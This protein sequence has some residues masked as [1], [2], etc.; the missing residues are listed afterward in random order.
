MRILHLTY[1]VSPHG[2]G[3]GLIALNLAKAQSA[4]GLDPVIWCLDSEAVCLRV[5]ETANLSPSRIRSFPMVG[6]SQFAFSPALHSAGKNEGSEFAVIH[7]HGIWTA[8]S[9]VTKSIVTR[10]CRP[11]VVA[12]HGSLHEFVLRKSL[13]KKRLASWAYESSNLQRAACLHATAPGELEDFRQYGLRNPIALITNGISDEW[14]AAEGDG[15]RFLSAY[16]IPPEARILLFMSR[17][18]PKKGLLML[19]Q[20]W[21]RATDSDSNWILVV[22]GGDEGGHKAE[23]ENL[24][25]QLN[26]S[27]RVRFVGPIFEQGKR[28]AFTASELFVLPSLS[29]GFPMVVLDALG[30]G[31]PAIVTHA[32]AW[33]DLTR[34]HC[35]WWVP[36]TT[37]GLEQGIRSAISLSPGELRDMGANGRA[38]VASRYNESTLARQTLELYGWL[39]GQSAQPQFVSTV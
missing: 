38:L 19:L 15:A 36:T 31:V 30:A 6:P 10:H 23:A 12:P 17:I 13:W 7:Q 22:V 28:D 39:R 24:C 20:A 32:S 2:Y 25:E 35:G 3:L 14:L 27:Q 16:A 18:T 34:H 1:S 11:S 33:E 21:A 5:A 9:N 37:E 29:E 8:M 26:L 4:I